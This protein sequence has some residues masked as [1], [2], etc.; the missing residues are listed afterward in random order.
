MSVANVALKLDASAS[1][2]FCIRITMPK[3]KQ[4]F[5]HIE[6][7]LPFGLLTKSAFGIDFELGDM[8]LGFW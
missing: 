3:P 7:P 4:A 2:Y 1:W 6:E 8:R 5:D